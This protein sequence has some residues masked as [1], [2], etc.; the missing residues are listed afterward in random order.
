MPDTPFLPE[1]SPNSTSVEGQNEVSARLSLMSGLVEKVGLSLDGEPASPEH[2]ATNLIEKGAESPRQ[3]YC[4]MMPA[5]TLFDLAEEWGLEVSVVRAWYHRGQWEKVRNAY[6]LNVPLSMGG[7]KAVG[8]LAALKD[9]YLIQVVSDGREIQRLA[10]E[11]MHA[12]TEQTAGKDEVLTLAKSGKEF[13]NEAIAY[14]TADK[15]VRT[16]FQLP[17]KYSFTAQH[18]VSERRQV[19]Q[20]TVREGANGGTNRPKAPAL[21]AEDTN[22]PQVF[23]TTYSETHTVESQG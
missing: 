8:D 15:M 4:T 9:D 3:R 7:R 13:L 22:K 20:V 10:M 5:I 18:S 1:N 2:G 23:E 11:R 16:A 6:L 19:K 14:D 21:L 12:L 17:T